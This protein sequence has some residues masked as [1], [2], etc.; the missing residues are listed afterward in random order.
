ML[1]RD[2]VLYMVALQFHFWKW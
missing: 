2:A 1:L